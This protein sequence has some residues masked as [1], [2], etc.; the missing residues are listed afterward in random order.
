VLRSTATI[1]SAFREG[2]ARN[3]TRPPADDFVDI[4]VQHH[5]QGSIDREDLPVFVQDQDRRGQSVQY[6]LQ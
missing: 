3:F 4:D 5:Q 2:A 1:R 6:R